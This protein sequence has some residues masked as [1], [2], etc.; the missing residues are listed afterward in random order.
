M[1]L[2]KLPVLLAVPQLLLVLLLVCSWRANRSQ[3][4]HGWLCSLWKV[5]QPCSSSARTAGFQRV[6]KEDL[7]T[8][9]PVSPPSSSTLATIFANRVRPPLAATLGVE[10][11]HT[12]LAA[13][14]RADCACASGCRSDDSF[15]VDVDFQKGL[16]QRTTG[17]TPPTSLA[18]SAVDDDASELLAQAEKR[19][20]ERIMSE[21]HASVGGWSEAGDKDAAYCLVS[22]VVAV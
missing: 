14:A 11:L 6:C 19:L 21:C 1:Q 9:E 13:K 2:L 3:R 7:F 4:P 8:F 15:T 20:Q 5:V 10:S 12:G 16:L 18:A 17:P 22:S